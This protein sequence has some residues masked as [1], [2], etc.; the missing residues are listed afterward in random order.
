M[1]Q[2]S[3]TITNGLEEAKE[4]E[5]IYNIGDYVELQGTKKNTTRTGYIRFKGKIAAFGECVG[6][7]LDKKINDGNNG[8][9]NDY[10][11]FECDDGK[12]TFIKITKIIKKLPHKILNAPL[13]NQNSN[14][15]FPLSPAVIEK[16]EEDQIK[17]PHK[18]KKKKKKKGNNASN[19]KLKKSKD[20]K[21]SNDKKKVPTKKVSTR[22]VNK[23]S[24]LSVKS[25][26]NS[27][28]KKRS[29]MKKT[30]KKEKKRK[31]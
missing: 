2:S 20:S 26:T 25:S 13:S 21:T 6:I 27:S 16:S 10:Q 28:Q 12:G 4:S 9:F 8:T 19:K 11:Y 18:K 5:I 1:S 29:S 17:S 22:K 24:N 14:E 3:D 23:S 7:E 31:D 30:P 15:S